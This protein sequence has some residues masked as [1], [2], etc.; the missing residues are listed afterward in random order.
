MRSKNLI[1][2]LVMLFSVLLFGC[3]G[4]RS[5][6]GIVL[7]DST[8][9]PLKN[10][11]AISF[12]EEVDENNPKFSMTT[13]STGKFNGTTRLVGYKKKLKLFVVLSKDSFVTQTILNPENDTVRLIRK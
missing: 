6:N 4:G 8:N 11:L 2:C 5:G 3:E 7:D 12:V 1:Y 10:V 9:L 13:D